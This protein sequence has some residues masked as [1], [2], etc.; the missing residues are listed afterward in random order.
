MPA[1][2]TPGGRIG[3]NDPLGKPGAKNWV[4]KRGGLPDYIREV[5]RG[6]N[7]ADP[8]A[9][10][11]QAIAA[12][13]RW[14]SGGGHVTPKVRAAAAAA[15]AHWEAMKGS[16]DLAVT[17]GQ[18]I[19]LD[20]STFDQNRPAGQG[21]AGVGGAGAAAAGQQQGQPQSLLTPQ[22]QANISAFQKAHGLP[23]TGQLDAAT[24]AWL[25]DPANKGASASPASVKKAAAA[26]TK[27]AKAAAAA[28]KQAASAQAKAQ[29]QAA[30]DAAKKAKA[31]Q[32]NQAANDKASA[33]AVAQARANGA[34]A[35]VASTKSVKAVSLSVPLVGTNDGA[36]MT[37]KPAFGGKKAAPFAKGGKR[38]RTALTALAQAK[39]RGLKM[40]A[41]ASLSSSGVTDIDLGKDGSKWSHGYIPLNA[42]A[43]ALKLHKVP[44]GG[45]GE[46][47]SSAPMK[48]I[49]VKVGSG[50]SRLAMMKHPAMARTKVKGD[51]GRVSTDAHTQKRLAADRSAR[52]KEAIAAVEAF[53]ATGKPL[54]PHGDQ[55]AAKSP[56]T[57]A[58][59]KHLAQLH[60]NP[61]HASEMTYG[62]HEQLRKAELITGEQGHAKITEAGIH[63]ATGGKV[64]VYN[65]QTG[66]TE[67]VSP[68]E[69]NAG[70]ARY[71]QSL[72]AGSAAAGQ[73]IK[74]ALEAEQ[75][76]RAAYDPEAWRK[77]NAEGN[78]KSQAKIDAER[79]RR[80]G[81]S[82]VA[83]KKAVRDN[84]GDNSEGADG[85]TPLGRALQARVAKSSQPSVHDVGTNS[86]GE[87]R[88][89]WT[90]SQLRTQA[91]FGDQAAKDEL[92]RRAAKR[93]NRKAVAEAVG[94]R[95]LS[96]VVVRVPPK[97][98]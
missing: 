19:D 18:D 17:G 42:A 5:A 84:A 60:E 51:K 66:K 81:D 46:G 73:T 21:G 89:R 83:P 76:R 41:T 33:A 52:E 12:I 20:W 8:E 74:N 43:V 25:N 55:E 86:H 16:A 10:I 26:Q 71:G 48:A 44:A 23:A 39:K 82:L 75:A 96:P 92:A 24:V 94:N 47:N 67:Y 31:A 29:K 49:H 35:R 90:A 50:K 68:A 61:S 79:A 93:A 72:G 78:A 37:G 9:A 28:Q 95:H 70:H 6:I 65:V 87:D 13:K 30:T 97:K 53:H 36:R 69:A 34:G 27:A 88:T 15:L 58:A 45:G 11:P 98:S 77:A 40:P 85:L 80:S 32:A 63:A 54:G 14:A 2:V 56:L 22:T 62:P 3:N 38:K 1:V 64:Q 91:S 57:P 7:P 4:A 59:K